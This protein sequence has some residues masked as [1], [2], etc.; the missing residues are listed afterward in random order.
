MDRV[1]FDSEL[2]QPTR[3]AAGQQSQPAADCASQRVC[4][5]IAQLRR[6][7]C[8]EMFSSST[9]ESLNDSGGLELRLLVSAGCPNI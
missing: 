3:Q 6:R 2:A 4:A 5:A 8:P 7:H 1:D 9:P